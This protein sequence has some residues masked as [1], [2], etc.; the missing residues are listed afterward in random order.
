MPQQGTTTT[1]QT[2]SLPS[3]LTVDESIP[4]KASSH[5]HNLMVLREIQALKQT[6]ENI[7]TEHEYQFLQLEKLVTKN[8]NRVDI[9]TNIVSRF[10]QQ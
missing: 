4:P 1:E 3:N 5:V 10:V 6:V 2:R 7:C 9:L 8:S